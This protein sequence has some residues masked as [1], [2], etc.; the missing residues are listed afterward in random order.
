MAEPAASLLIE[1]GPAEIPP[2]THVAAQTTVQPVPDPASAA[3]TD[4]PS[5]DP[6]M[7]GSETETPA[8]A[9]DQGMPGRG[10]VRR[11]A[12]R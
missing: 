4:V 10:L 12:R 5:A 11:A 3:L 9:E 2:E 1:G 7:V 6:A 8:A